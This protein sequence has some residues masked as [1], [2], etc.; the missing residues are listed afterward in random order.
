MKWIDR[1]K[2]GF[3]HS[4]FPHLAVLIPTE[5]RKEKG[6]KRK[7]LMAFTEVN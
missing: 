2:A 4:H 1:N 7:G 3:D 5:E 6:E